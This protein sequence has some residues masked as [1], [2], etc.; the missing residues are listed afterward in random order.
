MKSEKGITLISVT[1][2][3]IVM[4]I[5]VAVVS[6]VTSYFYNNIQQYTVKTDSINEYTKFNSY[7]TEEINTKGNKVLECASINNNTNN[8][9]PEESYVVFSTNNQYTYIPSNKAIYQHYV[10]IA[11]GVEDCKF[12]HLI[13]NGKDAVK[14]TLKFETLN[15]E[16]TYVIK[17]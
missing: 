13:E 10:K 6:V 1:I 15:K 17:N 3:V 4:L 11:S 16:I 14:V 7:F 2:Y 9:E 5:T 8:D 12:E